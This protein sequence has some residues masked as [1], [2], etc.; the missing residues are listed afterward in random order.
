M[1]DPDPRFILPP[2]KSFILARIEGVYRGYA[3][4]AEF[5][6]QPDP[7]FAKVIIFPGTIDDQLTSYKISQFRPATANVMW[8]F[9]RQLGS[10]DILWLF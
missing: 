2:L 6:L 5:Q 4:L 10:M 1:D 7:A 9:V 8:R 3:T